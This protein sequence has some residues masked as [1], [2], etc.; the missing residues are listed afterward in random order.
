M[1]ESPELPNWVKYPLDGSSIVDSVDDFVLPTTSNYVSNEEVQDCKISTPSKKTDND[2]EEIS[3]ILK[4]RYTSPEEVVKA[5]DHCHVVVSES[6]VEKV[7]KRF[8]N[9]WIPAFGFFRWYQMQS[10]YKPSAN[11]YDSV[12]D[13]LG[14]T[15]MF[16]IMWELVVEMV[17]LG[18]LISLTTMSKIMRRLARGGKYF[19]AIVAF[20]EMKRFG[21]S[22]D[23]LAMNVL[24]DSLCKERGVEYALDAFLEFKNEMPPNSHTFNVLIHGCCKARQLNKAQWALE[25]MERYGIHPC[26][27]SYTSMI[28][29]YCREKDFRKVDAILDE[30][31]SKGCPPNVVTYTIV[32]HS[33]GKAKETYEA[34]GIYERMK[35]NGCVPDTSFY[36]SLIYIL[37]KAGR[38]KDA[39]NIYEEMSKNGCTP[40]VTTY[41]TMI[42]VACDHSQVENALKLLQEMEERPCKPD[43]K[44]YAPLLKM[45]CQKKWMRILFFLL[46]DMFKKGISIEIGTY[47]L[48]VNG[49]CKSG[50]LG[51]ACLFFEEMV[52]KGLLPWSNTY[53]RL[54]KELERKDMETEKEKIRQLMEQAKN[55]EQTC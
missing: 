9:D 34:M 39:N 41:N 51:Q 50:N 47:S 5:L 30:M 3:T 29:A 13:I 38:I 6:M 24:L 55:G 35:R 43:L 49:L 22:K 42:S 26:V 31:Q 46:D 33:L 1:N 53:T 25:E 20:R 14:K 18:G 52:L 8:S 23:I 21:L 2:V 11:L 7:L 17:R 40:D 10:T 4:S 48:L 12:V 54:V 28:E 16:D 44:T 19:D 32:M 45:C 37:S 15:K 27:I 36:N